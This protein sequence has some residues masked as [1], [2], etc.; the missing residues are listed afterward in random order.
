MR[1]RSDSITAT[2]EVF[3]PSGALDELDDG[4]GLSSCL[5]S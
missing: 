5:A 1:S 3:V 4:G 2:L